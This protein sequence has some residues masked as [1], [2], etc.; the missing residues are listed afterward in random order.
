MVV[1]ALELSASRPR[2]QA[3]AYDGAASSRDFRS[4]EECKYTTT[5]VRH[6]K[7]WFQTFFNFG[8]LALHAEERNSGTASG[9]FSF[10]LKNFHYLEGFSRR[11]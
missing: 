4:V 1:A 3:I 7:S 8:V 11:S 9:R 10:R 6:L 2:F 5:H